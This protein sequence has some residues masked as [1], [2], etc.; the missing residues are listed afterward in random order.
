MSVHFILGYVVR[1]LGII[2]IVTRIGRWRNPGF[3][4]RSE[5]FENICVM[6]HIITE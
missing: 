5:N 6:L 4:Q 1:R 2:I 3:S